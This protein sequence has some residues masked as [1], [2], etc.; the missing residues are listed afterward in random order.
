MQTGI[1]LRSIVGQVLRN[2]Q[3]LD[4]LQSNPFFKLPTSTTFPIQNKVLTFRF[5]SF[6]CRSVQQSLAKSKSYSV[7]VPQPHHAEALKERLKRLNDL[8]KESRTSIDQ[9][10]SD[11]DNEKVGEPFKMTF[12]E[13]FTLRIPSD[14]PRSRFDIGQKRLHR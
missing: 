8:D 2:Q 10:S 6:L 3:V 13:I 9:T 11:E 4:C 1:Y 12:V 7:V 5:R 14:V